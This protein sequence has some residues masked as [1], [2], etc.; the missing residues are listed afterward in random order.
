VG[1]VQTVKGLCCFLAESLKSL[2]QLGNCGDWKLID[3]CGWK[4][5]SWRGGSALPK[6]L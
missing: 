3:C 4:M 6:A 2:T 5:L 1:G